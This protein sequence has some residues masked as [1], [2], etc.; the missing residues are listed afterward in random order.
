MNGLALP[1]LDGPDDEHYRHNDLKDNIARLRYAG[2]ISE[3]PEYRRDDQDTDMRRQA[4]CCMEPDLCFTIW[5]EEQDQNTRDHADIPWQ[6]RQGREDIFRQSYFLDLSC[7]RAVTGKTY[8]LICPWIIVEWS[9][10]WRSPG[11]IE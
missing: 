7:G 3:N 10:I 2:S 5:N 4:L 9:R 8:G 11:S 1:G 6:I